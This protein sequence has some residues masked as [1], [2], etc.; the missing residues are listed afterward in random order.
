MTT[1][2][3]IAVVA[4][5]LLAAIC[6]EQLAVCRK[7]HHYSPTTGWRDVIKSTW[8]AGTFLASFLMF[9]FVLVLKQ[10]VLEELGRAT[11]KWLG[12]VG[13]MLK[14]MGDATLWLVVLSGILILVLTRAFLRDESCWTAVK[15]LL[16]GTQ[17]EIKR[18]AHTAGYLLL[19]SVV[20]LLS[21]LIIQSLL[22]MLKG[23]PAAAYKI[24][25]EWFTSILVT[26]AFVF[27]FAFWNYLIFRHAL[28]QGGEPFKH[29]IRGHLKDLVVLFLTAGVFV[30]GLLRWA[31][32]IANHP[33]RVT[34][35]VWVLG[36]S[37]AIAAGLMILDLRFAAD[38]E[39][40]RVAEIPD[41][42]RELLIFHIY[43]RDLALYVPLVALMVFY[44]IH[45][46]I[47]AK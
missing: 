33:Q 4:A 11:E 31:E 2:M 17:E 23:V 43:F 3:G 24:Y 16:Y 13:Q 10:S 7:M 45:Q 28:A 47:G 1:K 42:Q 46:A 30:S 39:S 36:S 40:K 19:A 9:L 26:L 21:Y 14:H 29:L 34:I 32:L 35:L 5:F 6:A 12:D 15:S 20:L 18:H 44:S 38:I 27:V 37:L 25:Q 22:L 8:V 41:S